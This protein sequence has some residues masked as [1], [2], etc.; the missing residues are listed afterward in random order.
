MLTSP[1]IATLLR[2]KLCERSW[3]ALIVDESHVLR[4]KAKAGGDAQQTEAIARIASS[5]SVPHM[6]LLSGTP[7]LSRPF[8]LWRQID[9]LKPGLLGRDDEI[10]AALRQ[11]SSEARLAN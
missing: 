10:R 5:S 9:F 6:L 4:S 2:A 3:K 8:C 11:S 1:R 7:S